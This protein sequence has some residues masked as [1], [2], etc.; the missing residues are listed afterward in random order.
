MSGLEQGKL[1]PVSSELPLA[2][3]APKFPLGLGEQELLEIPFSLLWLK[4]FIVPW[5]HPLV[6]VESPC[7]QTNPCW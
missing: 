6:G 3:A 1:S 4:T 7:A 5:K 2:A